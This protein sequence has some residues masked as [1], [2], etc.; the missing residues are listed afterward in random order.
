MNKNQISS[1]ELEKKDKHQFS[2]E[3][4]LILFLSGQK[5]Y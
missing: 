5:H 3:I 1:S 4:D 2:V